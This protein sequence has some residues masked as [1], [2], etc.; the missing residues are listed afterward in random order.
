[1][2]NQHAVQHPK[3]Y[4]NSLIIFYLLLPFAY[5][6]YVMFSMSQTNNNYYDFL[7]SDPL[8]PILLLSV[9]ICLIW[10]YILW[11]L[12]EQNQYTALPS[13]LMCIA[14]SQLFIGNIV[15]VVFTFITRVKTKSFHSDSS[16]QEGMLQCKLLALL[17]IVLTLIVVIA[18]IRLS[19]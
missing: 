7:Y 8:N 1:M 6:G 3:R 5:L 19:F 10:A 2:K 11:K 14:I 17:N 13:Y 12:K 18:F 9:M 4:I 16:T 15:G